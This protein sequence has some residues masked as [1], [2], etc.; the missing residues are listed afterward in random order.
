[1]DFY[2]LPRPPVAAW[3]S[4]EVVNSMVSTQMGLKPGLV[5]QA[6]VIDVPSGRNPLYPIEHF[7]A[8]Q[9]IQLL[10]GEEIDAHAFNDTNLTRSLDAMF[11]CGT[12]KIVTRRL[13]MRAAATFQLDLGTTGYDTTSTNVWGEYPR[14]ARKKSRL[15]GR[16]L[17]MALAR[18]INPN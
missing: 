3:G 7:I 4:L 17:L 15:K 5:A 9:D 10:L 16:S 8:Q 11:E 12:A 2:P 14:C 13:E 18:T 1:M 6:M